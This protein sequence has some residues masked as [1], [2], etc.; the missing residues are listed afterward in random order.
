VLNLRA[1]SDRGVFIRVD[2]EG[3]PPMTCFHRPPKRIVCRVE[4]VMR[5]AVVVE[6]IPLVVGLQRHLTA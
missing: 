3:R 6:L 1:T 5:A 4:D 2:G